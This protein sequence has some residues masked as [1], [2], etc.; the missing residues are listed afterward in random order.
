V[1]TLAEVFFGE[2][3]RA[4]AVRVTV[5]FAGDVRWRV[6]GLATVSAAAFCSCGVDCSS[7]FPPS[8]SAFATVAATTPVAAEA[9]AP[10]AAPATVFTV[11]SAPLIT[12]FFFL[13]IRSLWRFTGLLAGAG[14]N[15]V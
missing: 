7:F 13:M 5:R 14:T 3:F 6:S 11:S 12:A 1:E 10:A 9:A 2:A 4:A 8:L 15:G